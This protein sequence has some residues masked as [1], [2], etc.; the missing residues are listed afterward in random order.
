MKPKFR[1]KRHVAFNPNRE[2]VAE[3]VEQYL[4]NGGKIEQLKDQPDRRTEATWISVEDN[5]EADEF[6]TE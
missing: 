1:R 4:Q 6:L 5:S 3:A 2:Y